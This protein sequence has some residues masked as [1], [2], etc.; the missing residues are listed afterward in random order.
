MRPVGAALGRRLELGDG[1]TTRAGAGGEAGK[2]RRDGRGPFGDGRERGEEVG[3]I[4]PASL[5]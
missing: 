4:G 3:W 5:G 2:H 1:Q